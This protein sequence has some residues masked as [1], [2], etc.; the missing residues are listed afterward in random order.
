MNGET[1]PA[2]VTLMTM[3]G[4]RRAASTKETVCYTQLF[5]TPLNSPGDLE[6]YD[7]DLKDKCFNKAHKQNHA[8]VIL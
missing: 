8:E 1:I 5:R 3:P 6:R 2:L 4:R 7:K